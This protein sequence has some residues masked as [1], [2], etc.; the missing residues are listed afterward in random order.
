MQKKLNI[1]GKQQFANNAH[2]VS[3]RSLAVILLILFSFKASS[4]TENW[5][6]T[7][8]S[9]R[10]SGLADSLKANKIGDKTY[11]LITSR[12]LK[13]GDEFL[14][15]QKKYAVKSGNPS[16]LAYVSY[17]TAIRYYGKLPMDSIISILQGGAKYIEQGGNH[18]YRSKIFRTLAQAYEVSNQLEQ[19]N[20]NIIKS[21]YS[22][23]FIGDVNEIAKTNLAFGIILAR[24]ERPRE[25]LQKYYAAIEILEKIKDN[26]SLAVAYNAV[27]NILLKE[28]NYERCFEYYN[29]NLSHCRDKFPPYLPTA[30][31]GVATY[32]YTI[33][34]PDEALPYYDSAEVSMGQNIDYTRLHVVYSNKATIYQEKNMPDSAELYQRK[35]I[36]LAESMTKMGYLGRLYMNFASYLQTVKKLDSAEFYINKAIGIS[37]EEGDEDG[38]KDAYRMKGSILFDRGD[39]VA[40]KAAYERSIIVRDSIA[41]ESRKKEI[42]R[43][44]EEY[45]SS[46]KLEEIHRLENERKI[47]QLQLEKKNAII[48]GNLEEARRRQSEIDVLNKENIIQQLRLTE[49]Q[50]KLKQKMLEAEAKEQALALSKK[51]EELKEQEIAQQKNSKNLI[52]IGGI[53][54]LLFLL[55][56]FNQYRISQHRKNESERYQLQH[57]LSELKIEALRAQ[58]NPHFIFNAL[59]SINRYIIRSD[60]E[61]ASDYLVKFSKLMRLVLENS[62]SSLVTLNNETD[63]LRLYIE[64]EQLRFDHK[65]EYSITIDPAIDR[66]R[67]MIPPLVLQPYVENAIWHGLLNK[68]AA[69]TVR[70]SITNKNNNSLFCTVEDD[71]IGREKAA[72]M[73][74]KTL[75]SNKSFGTEI[76]RE[77]IKLLNG[78]DR[79]FRI[80][81]LYD[82]NQQ[83]AG[84]RVEITLQTEVA[85]AA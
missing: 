3:Y 56:G 21:E 77:R 50:Q 34:K 76:T 8:T 37:Q 51:Q 40:A 42:N 60:R 61:T 70:I 35:T 59:N 63:A 66:E 57:Q 64:M 9:I 1:P 26:R 41:L 10:N 13:E 71:G 46:K 25:A 33:N 39:F 55:L 14:T 69:G 78:D 11:I 62:K 53:A 43:L 74:S 29:R 17:N 47:Q 24:L 79:N 38:I 67:T 45:E 85:T 15:E 18:L 83:P 28:Q 30:Y 44:S 54:L 16:S 6:D 81:D 36:A 27:G 23:R 5:A 75:G 68:G 82:A 72:E 52:I 58:M 32:Y 20:E 84:T 48:A 49:Q 22:A 7:L 31:L 2:P 65:F 19:A 4:Q 80:I 12:K 73:K